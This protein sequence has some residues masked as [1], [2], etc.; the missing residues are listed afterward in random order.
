MSHLKDIYEL[1]EDKSILNLKF[2]FISKGRQDVVKVVQYAFVQ[3]LNGRNVYNL[4]FDDYDL[5][6]DVIIDHINTN[7]GD[8]YKVFNTILSTIP[9]FFKSYDGSILMVQGS[10]GRPEF[11]EHCR[12]TCRKKCLNECKNHNRRITIYRG[13]INKHY[14]ALTTEYHFFGGKKDQAQHILLEPYERY[15]TYDSVFIFQKKI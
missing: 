1:Q 7:N 5:D 8:A 3:K 13:Y 11:P 6:N 2:F 15:K 12:L 10:D 9:G 14:E 4:G